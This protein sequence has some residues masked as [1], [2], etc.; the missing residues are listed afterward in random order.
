MVGSKD[1]FKGCEVDVEDIKMR[2]TR[3][4]EIKEA[5]CKLDSCVEEKNLPPVLCLVLSES[6]DIK[7]RERACDLLCAVNDLSCIEPIRNHTFKVEAFEHR[8]N[9]AI[10]KLL[11]QN[12]MIEIIEYLV[13]DIARKV[14]LNHLDWMVWVDVVG[15]RTAISLLKPEDIFSL[16]LP[17]P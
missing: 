3:Y 16:G 9:L 11:Q 2:N 17:H 4:A 7:E 1:A 6:A 5:I 8:V 10:H 14:E 12:Y 15:R 13:A